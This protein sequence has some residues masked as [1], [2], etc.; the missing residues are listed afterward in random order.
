MQIKNNKIF[1]KIYGVL[2]DIVKNNLNRGD[3]ICIF[4]FLESYIKRKTWVEYMVKYIVED[5]FKFTENNLLN[6]AFIKDDE[7]LY[8]KLSSFI[9]INH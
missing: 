3:I 6:L 5:I 1:N 4:D 7:E 9:Q 2:I 8:G